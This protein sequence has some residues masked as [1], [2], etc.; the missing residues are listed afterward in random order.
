[1]ILL[2]KLNRE[3]SLSAHR[4]LTLQKSKL[5]KT[6][7]LLVFCILS[8]VM[9]QGQK[10]GE[11]E[12]KITVNV[13]KFMT[14]EMEQYKSF[15]P[16]FKTSHKLLRFNENQSIYEKKEMEVTTAE[17]HGH[18]GPFG[19]EA[20]NKRHTDLK[21]KTVLKKVDA[22]GKTYLVTGDIESFKWK[23][24]GKSKKI[25]G[26]PCIS[27]EYSD[28]AMTYTA[29]FTPTMPVQL[30]PEGYGALPGLI[31]EMVNQDSSIV[32]E[33]VNLDKRAVL[34]DEIKKPTK[35]KEMTQEEFE[36][37]VADK[38]KE[39]EERSGRKM[40]AGMRMF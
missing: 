9:A 23:I 17:G 18:G 32:I 6:V 13:H 15:V 33:T 21:T 30:G 25:K 8:I 27:A 14:G 36:K 35:G 1:M 28:T 3:F 38:I 20:D 40:P 2:T 10:S 37:L 24:T 19:G 7:L 39:F 34:D 12:Y 16:E 22:F 29:W 26:L 11:I 5:M 4:I 31:L